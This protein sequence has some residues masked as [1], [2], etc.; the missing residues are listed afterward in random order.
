MISNPLKKMKFV[1]RLIAA[2]EEKVRPVLDCGMPF[3]KIV[4]MREKIQTTIAAFILFAS[5]S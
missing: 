1:N 5:L 3:D 4:T 2:L